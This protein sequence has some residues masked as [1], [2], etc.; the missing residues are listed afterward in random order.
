MQIEKSFDS[1][2]VKKIIRGAYYAVVPAAALALLNY[3]GSLHVSNPV[4]AS[5][6]VWAVPVA[7]NAVKEWKA[8]FP[9]G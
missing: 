9:E 7:V 4:L 3:I 5:L 2:T 1:A 8:G 6:V